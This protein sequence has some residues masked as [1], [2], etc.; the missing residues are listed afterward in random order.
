MLNAS[1]NVFLDEL[2]S[3]APVPGGGSASAYVGALGMALG[4]MVGDLTIGKKKYQN[5]EQDLMALQKKSSTIM[6]Q[7]KSIVDED[8][9]VFYPLSQAYGLVANTD[10]ER[11]MKDEV[12][13]SLLIQATLV[14]MEII[15]C[16]CEAIEFH[17]EYAEKGTKLALSDV[18]VGVMFCMASL[19]GAKLNVLINTKIMNDQELKNQIEKELFELVEVGTKA[20]FEIFQQVE[21]ELRQS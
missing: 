17:R 7:L 4:M 14:P 1:C 12:L 8:A 11:K 10:S 20:A 3:K 13:Q 5:F 9:K 15:R 21:S 2:S 19:Q 6:E 16:C 18:G